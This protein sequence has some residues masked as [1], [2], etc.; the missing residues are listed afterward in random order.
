MSRQKGGRTAVPDDSRQP[1]LYR[2]QRGTV[3]VV[4]DR[5]LMGPFTRATRISTITRAGQEISAL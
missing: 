1:R 5:H 4:R 2:D 3:E